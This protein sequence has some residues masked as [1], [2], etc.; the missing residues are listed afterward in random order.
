MCIRDSFLRRAGFRE[1]ARAAYARALA[2]CDNR[3][4]A[5]FLARRIDETE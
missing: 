2:L 3:A 4:E 5:A 1:Q